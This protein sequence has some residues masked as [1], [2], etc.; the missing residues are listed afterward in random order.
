MIP[1]NQP[2]LVPRT[3]HRIWIGSKPLPEATRGYIEAEKYSCANYDRRL[4]T[5]ETIPGLYPFM[6][7]SSATMLQDDRLNPVVKSDV[8]RYE[9]LRLFGGVYV[10][11]DVEMFRNL[12]ELLHIPFVC[13]D[14]GA[15]QVGTAFLTS[16]PY[17]P[18]CRRMLE[19]VAANYAKD[20]P[21]AN[22][23]QQMYFGGPS[24]FTTIVK[25][26]PG[27]EVLPREQFYPITGN[28]RIPGALHYFDG[29]CTAAGW[30]HQ[31]G[32]V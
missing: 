17:H 23:H 29:G 3:I 1:F 13:V 22:A 4:W 24:L 6:L 31:V 9:L 21:P 11:T 20:G 2:L 27:I 26:F 28:P 5:N 30:V 16:I 12:D 19:A 14:E 32:T 25:Q 10:D 8:L 18:I 15:G 7:Q